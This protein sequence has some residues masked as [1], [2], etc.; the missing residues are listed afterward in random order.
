MP[1]LSPLESKFA[2]SEE[3]EVHDRWFRAKVEAAL[4]STGAKIPH[5]EAMAKVRAVIES[6]RRALSRLDPGSA[7]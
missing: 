2:S 6:K 1:T 3:A 5:D 7:G 4:A